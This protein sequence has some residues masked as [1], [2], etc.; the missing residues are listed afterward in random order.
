MYARGK[1]AP[2]KTSTAALGSYKVLLSRSAESVYR[3]LHLKDPKLFQR[4]RNVLE[5]LSSDPFQGKPLKG[6]LAGRFSYRLGSYRIL[7]SIQR[8][9]LVVFIIDIGHRREI[10][11]R[12]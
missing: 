3:W 7:Y 9:E 2:W 11:R 1:P 5:S 10:Y 12:T 8:Q 6:P 4:I